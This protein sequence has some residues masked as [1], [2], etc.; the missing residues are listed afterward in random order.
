MLID[1][2]ST[3]NFINF[4]LTKLHN[5]FVFPTPKFQVMIVDGD[6]TKKI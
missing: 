6:T 1:S 2:S 5:C 3:H 4:K